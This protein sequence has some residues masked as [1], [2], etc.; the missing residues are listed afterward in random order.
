MSKRACPKCGSE[1]VKI[2]GILYFLHQEL[3]YGTSEYKVH[4]L[5]KCMLCH[6]YISE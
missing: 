4:N 6:A 1:S 5:Y 2:E 3:Q